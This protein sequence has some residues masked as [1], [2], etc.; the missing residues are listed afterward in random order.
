MNSLPLE[1]TGVC[2]PKDDILAHSVNAV[3]NN[4]IQWSGGNPYLR[5]HRT[6]LGQL[7]SAGDPITVLI[8][9]AKSETICT[10]RLVVWVKRGR[11]SQ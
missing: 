1:V 9:G 4:P 10:P 2:E 6:I 7:S 11:A 3:S 5:I 8:T